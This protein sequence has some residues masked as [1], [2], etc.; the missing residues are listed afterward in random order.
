MKSHLFIVLFFA[1]LACTTTFAQ[2][3]SADEEVDES[4][5][6]APQRQMVHPLTDMPEASPDIDSVV[7]IPKW[8]AGEM[9]IGEAVSAVV[10]LVNNGEEAVQVAFIMGSI[11]SPFD[12][13]FHVQ[14][15]SLLPINVTL[16]AG[17]ERTFEYK[18]MPHP[19]LD[20]IELRVALTIFYEELGQHSFSTTFYN[21]SVTFIEVGPL[22]DMKSI[23]KYSSGFG[24][25]FALLFV[26]Y[27]I[28]VG[29]TKKS[30]KRRKPAAPAKQ[31]SAGADNEWLEGYGPDLKQGKKKKN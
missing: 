10:G 22:I 3:D 28:F 2:D 31:P 26:L 6:A 11:N 21:E 25:G 20:P 24:I 13:N 8:N 7:V 1:L 30:Q 4:Y 19:S 16:D 5:Q 23:S 15:F 27:Q 12:F 29:P 9:P 18:F 17:E 14:N